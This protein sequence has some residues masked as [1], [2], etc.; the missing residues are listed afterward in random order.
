MRERNRKISKDFDLFEGY[1]D[2]RVFIP[3]EEMIFS[4]VGS[5]WPPIED[6]SRCNHEGKEVV[7]KLVNP[8]K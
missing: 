7:R 8:W 5:I 2:V 4:D 6:H 1:C 3:V